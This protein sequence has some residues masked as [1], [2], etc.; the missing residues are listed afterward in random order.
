[1]S[2]LCER[3]AKKR[4][5]EQV[6]VQVQPQVQVQVQ[7]Q[8]QVEEESDYL[9]G[10]SPKE[11]PETGDLIKVLQELESAAS[12]DAAVRQKIASLP[13]EVQDITLLDRINDRESA[14]QL[15]N[16]VEQACLLLAD[17]NG[18]LAAELE[19]RRQLGRMLADYTRKQREALQE[20]ERKLEDY[21][22][23][24]AR[25]AQVRK[26][27]KSHLQNLPDLSRLPNVTG[28][29]APLPSAGDLFSTE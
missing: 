20:K 11:P 6:Q 26:E 10:S 27:L 7:A 2:Q 23:K 22:Q 1:M 16:T 3:K 15:A 4:P 28:G 14:E 29:L 24:L 12:G 5:L 25:V 17:Y 8:A 18:R 13:P 19:D 21:K 9:T